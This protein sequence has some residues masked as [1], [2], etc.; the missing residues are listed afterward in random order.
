MSITTNRLLL[1]NSV[2][3]WIALATCFILLAPLSAMQFTTAVDWDAAD[4]IVMGLLLFS[5][6]TGFVLAAR[7]ISP[8]YRMALGVVIAMASLYAWAE[9]AVGI[10]TNLGS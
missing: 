9:L 6:G 2:F 4:F 1:R 7:K 10:F 8:R 3:A 5:A